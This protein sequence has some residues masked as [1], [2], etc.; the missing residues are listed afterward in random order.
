MVA[1][2]ALFGIANEQGVASVAR[3]ANSLSDRLADEILAAGPGR[4][5]ELRSLALLLRLRRLCL[6]GRRLGLFGG[7]G[8]GPRLLL[9]LGPSGRV[10]GALLAAHML[11][12][13][14]DPVGAKGRLAAV[15]G[16][17]DPHANRLLD[18][19][20]VQVA[21]RHPLFRLES[22]AILGKESASP[23]LLHRAPAIGRGVGVRGSRRGGSRLAGRWRGRR[24]LARTGRFRSVRN[25]RTGGS[26][27]I[28]YA[29]DLLDS[30]PVMSARLEMESLLEPRRRMVLMRLMYLERPSFSFSV[31]GRSVDGRSDM[32]ADQNCREPSDFNS[33]QRSNS[34][35][36]PMH[37]TQ[38]KNTH[39]TK[40]NQVD[41]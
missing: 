26:N 31:L 39:T 19:L 9:F 11:A 38:S 33:I 25:S 23:L 16:P 32:V 8:L 4:N 7:F 20:D 18:T 2:R 17:A 28:A 13:G 29:A 6:S 21:R 40:A 41:G 30:P 14:A 22:Q 5:G 35:L 36:I 3:P 1:V 27:G 15:A 37:L 24:I 10:T 12:V 34:N